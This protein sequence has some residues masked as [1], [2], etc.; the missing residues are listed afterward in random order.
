MV[1]HAYKKQDVPPLRSGEAIDNIIWFWQ[2][3]TNTANQSGKHVAD[4]GASQ[5]SFLATHQKYLLSS[6]LVEAS[7]KIRR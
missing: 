5:G 2:I 6:C 3:A 4:P 7:K 1:N